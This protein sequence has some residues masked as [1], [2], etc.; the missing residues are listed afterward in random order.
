M[1]PVMVRN[2]ATRCDYDVAD[3]SERRFVT[4]IE[5]ESQLALYESWPRLWGTIS[6]IN[7]PSSAYLSASADQRDHGHNCGYKMPC[8]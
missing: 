1:E 6:F 3:L 7:W 4:L 8:N 5:P 2:N